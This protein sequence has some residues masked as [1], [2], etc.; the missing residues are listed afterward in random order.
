MQTWIYWFVYRGSVK[1]DINPRGSACLVSHMVIL[2]KKLCSRFV[3]FVVI[4]FMLYVVSLVRFY[5]VFVRVRCV[6]VQ[7]DLSMFPG[8]NSLTLDSES[9]CP[10]TSAATLKSMHNWSDWSSHYD[11][12]VMDTVASQITSLAI[13]Y[14]TVY[15]GADQRKHQSSAFLAF[16]RGIHR[17]PV[18]SPH[19]WPVTRKMFPFDDVIM[20]R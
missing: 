1:A 2:H 7:L 11:D 13:V 12:V 4:S 20:R 18:N 19:K 10:I 16:V 5:F 9:D 3:D 15:S 17:G 14:S 6:L 8:T